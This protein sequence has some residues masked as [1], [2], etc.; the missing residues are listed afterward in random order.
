M[1]FFRMNVFYITAG[2]RRQSIDDKGFNNKGVRTS[3]YDKSANTPAVGL[4]VKPWNFMSGLYGNYIEGLEQG[5]TAPRDAVNAGEQ[6]PPSE[7]E[8][9]EFGV[10]FDLDWP[11]S[12]GRGIPDRTSKRNYR[13]NN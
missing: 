2:I 3:Q 7:T 4:L 9:V 8:Q 5:P 6:F 11:W 13:C 1:G 10:K 12:D